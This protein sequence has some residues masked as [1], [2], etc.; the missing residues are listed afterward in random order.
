MLTSV[1]VLSLRQLF[2]NGLGEP[3]LFGYSA[4][5]S[6]KQNVNS[7]GEG[8]NCR[9]GESRRGW[10]LCAQTKRRNFI[11]PTSAHSVDPSLDP[12]FAFVCVN[13]FLGV[14]HAATHPR[15]SGQQREAEQL[16][17]AFSKR[18][19]TCARHRRRYYRRRDKE[20]LT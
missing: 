15:I 6:A 12:R 17:G 14:A 9:E 20:A 8:G 1:L 7:E 3:G 4:E 18:C 2:V 10:P 5:T 11:A 13:S 19:F 16:I